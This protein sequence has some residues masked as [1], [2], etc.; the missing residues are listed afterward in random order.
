MS[1]VPKVASAE[2][3]LNILYYFKKCPAIPINVPN[4]T[5]IVKMIGTVFLSVAEI[6]ITIGKASV[7]EINA[8]SKHHVMYGKSILTMTIDTNRYCKKAEIIARLSNF[9]TIIGIM[10]I[11]PA[12][13]PIITDNNNESI[14]SCFCL[15]RN[16]YILFLQKYIFFSLSVHILFHGTKA[17]FWGKY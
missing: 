12:T 2:F 8:P 11:I 9:C 1:A 17:P 5:D 16:G 4:I 15:W 3:S 13:T 10:S 7:K 14:L 6:S